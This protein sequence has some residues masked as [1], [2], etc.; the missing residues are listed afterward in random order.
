MVGVITTSDILQGESEGADVDATT[1]K[2]MMTSPA[3]TTSPG[4]EL[5]EAA[6]AME[7]AEVHRLFVEEAGQLVGVV[8]L[9]DVNRALAAGRV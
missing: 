9:S 4:T 8:S 1:V 6:L 5:R 3:L 2:D 7:Y